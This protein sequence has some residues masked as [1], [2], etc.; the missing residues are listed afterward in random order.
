MRDLPHHLSNKAAALLL[1]IAMVFVAVVIHAAVT[2]D[3]GT[4]VIPGEH[5]PIRIP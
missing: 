3:G 2:S 5:D 4:N 1:S